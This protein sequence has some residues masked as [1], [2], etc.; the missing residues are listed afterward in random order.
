MDENDFFDLDLEL[1]NQDLTKQSDGLIGFDAKYLRVHNHIR[2]MLSPSD[3]E[4]WSATFH[5]ERSFL[6]DVIS[7]RHPIFIFSGD[8]GTGKTA[9]AQC[10]VN[11]LSHEMQREGRLLKLSTRVR[12][13]GLHGQMSQLIHSAFEKLEEA[14]GKRRLGFL[15]IDEA[16]ALSSLR[17]TEQMH[18]EEKAAVNT[19]IQKLDDLRRKGGR[20]A[21]FLCTNR[22]DVID[23]AVIRRTALH[24]NFTRPSADE[25]RELLKRDLFG[26][27]L[28]DSQ[29]DDLV[30]RTGS[31]ENHDIGYTY[32]DF[33]LRMLPDAIS[34]VFPNRPL[35]YEILKQSIAD[36]EPSPEIR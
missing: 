9:T 20:A 29:I 4:K 16:D 10:I 22:L 5:G 30:Q 17:A 25:R 32:S 7:Q 12:G 21:T 26:L 8:V 15:L 6:C 19:L 33:R 24:L 31:G 2:M 1:P 27:N 23:P 35:T 13:Q 3:L 34:R 14:T 18:Q 36:V 28:S 11:R